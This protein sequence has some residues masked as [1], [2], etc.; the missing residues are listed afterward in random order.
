MLLY[1]VSVQQAAGTAA[2]ETTAMDT[3]GDK[4][5]AEVRGPARVQSAVLESCAP[6]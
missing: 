3:S 5:A 6:T 4:E 1:A 2:A